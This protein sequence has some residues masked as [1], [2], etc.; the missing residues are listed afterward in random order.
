LPVALLPVAGETRRGWYGVVFRVK[1]MANTDFKITDPEALLA[2]AVE[3]Q[4]AKRLIG[5]FLG[6]PWEYVD[7]HLASSLAEAVDRL[8]GEG[9]RREQDRIIARSVARLL[10]DV[11]RTDPRRRDIQRTLSNR[12]R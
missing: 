1:A 5:L 3:C 2:R 10:P 12:I 9:L 7:A 6:C 8:P 4:E 11:P